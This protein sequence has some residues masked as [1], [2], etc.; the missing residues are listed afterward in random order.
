[1]IIEKL[2]VKGSFFV[3]DSLPFGFK[4]YSVYQLVF[5]TKN[6]RNFTL[7]TT[8]KNLNTKLCQVTVNGQR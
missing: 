8:L 4:I 2:P 1:M 7:K 5:E 3:Y 6:F